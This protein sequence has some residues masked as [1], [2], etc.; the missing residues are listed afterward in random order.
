MPG[1]AAA[2]LVGACCLHNLQTAL[3]NAIIGVFG[4][5]GVDSE[6]TE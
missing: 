4:E 2:Y 5:G 1:M 6:T 3:R